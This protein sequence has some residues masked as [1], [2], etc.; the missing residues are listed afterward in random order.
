MLFDRVFSAI[1]F[2]AMSVGQAS[3]FAPDYSKAK[4]AA[5]RMFGLFDR[6]PP[7]DSYSEDGDKPVSKLAV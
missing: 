2:G 1:V 4:V 6:V 7:I 3:Q 5:G